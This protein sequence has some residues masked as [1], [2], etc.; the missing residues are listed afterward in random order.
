[1]QSPGTY[2]LILKN[3]CSFETRVGRWGTLHTEPGYY[4]YVGSA[5]GPGGIQ[6][7]VK[8][9]ARAQKRLRWNIDY[10]TTKMPVIQSCYSESAKKLEHVWAQRLMEMTD[11]FPINRFGCSDCRCDT[12]LFFTARMK[13]VKKIAA[14]LDAD[15]LELAG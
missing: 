8:R 9:H 5:F 4:I 2:A 6:A 3:D 1:M 14:R 13:T 10:L 7:R 12:H 15:L 11:L